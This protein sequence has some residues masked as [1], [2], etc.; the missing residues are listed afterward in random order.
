MFVLKK[1]IEAN[2]LGHT[3]SHTLHKLFV[4]V[5]QFQSLTNLPCGLE[6]NNNIATGGGIMDEEDASAD[7]DEH[8]RRSLF[9]EDKTTAATS[10]DR[11][12]RG[13]SKAIQANGLGNGIQN[14]GGGGNG[15]GTDGLPKFRIDYPKKYHNARSMSLSMERNAFCELCRVCPDL[16]DSGE[17]GDD[18]P[19]VRRY[20]G[21]TLRQYMALGSLA[22][23]DFLGFCSMSV[24][25][26]T[27]PKEVPLVKHT[28]EGTLSA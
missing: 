16:A 15:G 22:L 24:M 7:D 1:T 14:S 8:I 10:S 23:V 5:L 28:C 6:S 3:T 4:C 13:S 25:A 18:K 27:F 21:F 11:T 12:R 26:P 2:L 17:P 20:F 19:G 9:D